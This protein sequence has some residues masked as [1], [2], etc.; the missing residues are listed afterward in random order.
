MFPGD[1]LAT[2]L[3]KN[4]ITELMEEPSGKWT[5]GYDREIIF[6]KSFEF[7]AN[8]LLFLFLA[9]GFLSNYLNRFWV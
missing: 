2:V 8:S 9:L 5:E 7:E 3:K 1:L 4:K 6:S